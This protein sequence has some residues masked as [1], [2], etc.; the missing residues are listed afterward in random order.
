[1]LTHLW[2]KLISAFALVIVIGVFITGVLTR[3]GA[4][5]HFAHFMVEHHMIRPG[6]MVQTLAD[7]YSLHSDWK[8]TN[9]HLPLLIEAASDGIMSGMIGS[10]MG[11]SENRIQVID[12]QD[13]VIADTITKISSESNTSYTMLTGQAIQRWPILVDNKEVGFLLVEGAMMTASPLHNER[14]LQGVT[15]AVSLAGLTTGLIAVALAWLLVR[16]ITSPLAT[17]TAA[18]EKI[19]KGDLAAR[20]TVQSN[21]ELGILA[22][23]F[24][25]MAT[26]LQTQE[27]L[28]RNLVADVAHELRTPLTGIQG[29]VE[30]IQDGVFPLTIEQVG[31]IHEQIMLLNRLVEDLRTLA[32]AEAGQLYL[33]KT[34]LDIVSL[35]KGQIQ[36]FRAQAATQQIE[37]YLN[38]NDT[39]SLIYAD[40]QRIG[41][42]LV[43]LLSNAL[44]H[45]P[46]GGRVEVAIVSTGRDVHVTVTDSGEGIA[47]EELTHIFERFYRTDRSRNRKN[48]GSGL[49][50]AITRQ[51]VEAH[52]GK[53][54]AES[55]PPGCDKGSR[56]TLVLPQ[57]A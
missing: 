39:P 4:A 53:L 57:N 50:L 2:F 36:A 52:E 27:T 8:D 10:M 33:D 3:Q 18:S 1:M 41:Q 35:C 26:N 12:N 45:T 40:P 14:L 24:N 23:T 42:V 19:A 43:N 54:W 9:S 47:A 29:T 49:G 22:T 15:R 16:Q 46:A 48:G 7:Y 34:S 44:R 25:Q 38:S 56:F 5:T 55:P 11:M 31:S 37:L 6:V 30:A 21:D 51:L 28:R 32:N 20:V 13:R 17:L